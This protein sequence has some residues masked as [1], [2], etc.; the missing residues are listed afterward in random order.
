MS[1]F[2]S[3]RYFRRLSGQTF[4]ETVRRLRLAGACSLL[5]DSEMPIASICYRAATRTS[6]TSTDSSGGTTGGHR[7]S[8]GLSTADPGPMSSRTV[9]DGG[10][11]QGTDDP[12]AQASP[13]GAAD[14]ALN[15]VAL[16]S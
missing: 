1:E 11:R 15:A 13:G 16:E 5:R 14:G 8:I 6:R 3:S 12:P 7:G 2:G 9:G 10:A 4:T